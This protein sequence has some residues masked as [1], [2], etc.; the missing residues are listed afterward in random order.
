MNARHVR[1]FNLIELMIV[2]AIV[3]ILTVVALPSL[4]ASLQ[5]SNTRSAAES[6]ENGIRFA[7]GE[8]VRLNRIATFT[9]AATGGW[10]VT[11]T[12]ISPPDPTTPGSNVLQTQASVYSSSL[13]VSPTTAI[14]FNGLGR[15]GAAGSFTTTS[16]ST[17]FTP[18]T[19]DPAVTYQITNSRAPRKLN[20]T[21]SPGGKIRMCDPDKSFDPTTTPDG[22]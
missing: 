2:V 6:I 15:A 9:P 7:Q 19:A 5:N 4:S 1:G 17:G 16:G 3:A 22:C 13:S 20:V 10:T 8:A 12:Q 14:S 21:V 11:Y 18:A